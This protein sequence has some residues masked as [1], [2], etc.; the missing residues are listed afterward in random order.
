MFSFFK[1]KSTLPD[2]PGW[3]SFFE[4]GEYQQFIRSVERYFEKKKITYSL[5]D[6]VLIA[7]TNGFG[8]DQLG[9]VNV[10]QVCKQDKLGNYSAIVSEH[11]DCMIRA[12][13]FDALFDSMVNDFD[14]VKQYIAVR[15]YPREYAFYNQQSLP[16]GKDLMGDIYAMLVFDLPDSIVG[17]LPE[18]ADRWNKTFDE[19]FS[20]GLQNMKEKY[21]VKIARHPFKDFI[22][23]L[24][25]GDHFYAP[26]IV[27]DLYNHPELLGSKGSLISIPHRH[28]VLVYPIENLEAVKALNTLIPVIHGMNQ[29]GPGSISNNL[30]WYKDGHFE[31]LPYKIEDKTLQFIPPA[32]FLDMLN[33]LKE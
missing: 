23:W 6:G 9:L 7:G 26:N 14:K 12:K 16:F 8:F 25:E 29:E 22:I 5:G 13:S 15:L 1:K 20:V 33:D 17:I 27:F 28:A 4:A 31:N 3:A 11:F 24:V 18:Q 19:L 21:T 30:F 32:N 2:V 10:A